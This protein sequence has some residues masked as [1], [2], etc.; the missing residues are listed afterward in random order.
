VS[1]PCRRLLGDPSG[2]R[3]GH[4]YPNRRRGR[5]PSPFGRYMRSRRSQWGFTVLLG[6]LLGETAWNATVPMAGIAPGALEVGVFAWLCLVFVGVELMVWFV[7]LTVIDDRGIRRH[8]LTRPRRIGWDEVADFS[9]EAY[10]RSARVFVHLHDG[11]RVRLYGVPAA[12]APGLL[13]L[14]GSVPPSAV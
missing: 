5:A 9:G 4:G 7:P 14:I 10:G 3:Y 11:R 8:G 13:N 1:A 12:A 2:E 6:L